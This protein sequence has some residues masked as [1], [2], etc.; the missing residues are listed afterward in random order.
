MTNIQQLIST[1]IS[2]EIHITSK[3]LLSYFTKENK[4]LLQTVEDALNWNNIQI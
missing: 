1:N 3:F 4:K 2:V